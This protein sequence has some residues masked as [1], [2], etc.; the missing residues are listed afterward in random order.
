[1][2][3]MSEGPKVLPICF[4]FDCTPP[5]P[6]RGGPST[7]YQFFEHNASPSIHKW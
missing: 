1:M 7:G 6:R 2:V 5:L 4:A 3:M